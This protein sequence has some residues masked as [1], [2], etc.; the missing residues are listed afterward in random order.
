MFSSKFSTE[1]TQTIPEGAHSQS[2]ATEA[3]A[4][5]PSSSP[6]SSSSSAFCSVLPSRAIVERQPRMLNFHVEYRTRTIEVV[7]EDASTVGEYW[8][9]VERDTD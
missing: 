3:S 6:P 2:T 1:A 9:Q 5:L 8:I 7:L 4:T